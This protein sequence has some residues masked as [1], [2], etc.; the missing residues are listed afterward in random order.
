[1]SPTVYSIPP[2]LPFVDE[3]ARGVME[4]AGHDPLALASHLILLPTR[5][6]CRS[7]R[8]AFLRLSKGKPLLLP[9][10]L[11]LGEVEEE[12]LAISLAS[13]EV[14]PAIPGLKRQLLL[15][16]L[17]MAMGQGRGGKPPGPE[18]AAR[19]AGELAKLLDQVQTE[20]LSFDLLE[21]LVPE[22]L[23]EHWQVTLKFL[24]ILTQN[25]PVLLEAHGAADPSTRRSLLLHAQAERW[26]KEPPHHPVIAAGSTGS[27]PAAAALLAVIANLPQ[28][29]VVLPGLDQHMDRTSWQALDE[30]H[31][32]HGMKQLL[33]KLE[34]TPDRV[35]P[36]SRTPN[37]RTARAWLIAEAMRPA[38]TTDLWRSL[39]AQAD[40]AAIEGVTRL[41]CPG[42]R[43]EAG[44]IAMLLR[45]ALETE[46][47]TAALITPDR[48]LARRVAAELERWD[49]EVDDSAGRPL[50]LTPPGVFL[51]LAAEMVA[52]NFSPHATLACLKHPLAAAGLRPDQCRAL[53]RRLEVV[54]LRGARPAPGIEG[55][56][57]ALGEKET[58]LKEWL[59]ILDQAARPFAA[60]MDKDIVPLADLVR[61]HMEFAEALATDDT[62]P[63][64]TRLWRGEAGEVA[65]NFAADLGEAAEAMGEVWP[66]AYPG[67]LACL[68]EGVVVRP[69]WGRHPRL[70]IWGLLEARL[71][72]AD[73]IILGG[74]NEGSW[75]PEADSDPWMSR[76]M[77]RD[78]GLPSPERRVGL[79]AHDFVQAFC[80]PRVVMTR[81]MK[82]EGT[83]TVPSRWLLRLETVMRACGLE[84]AAKGTEWHAPHWLDWHTLLDAPA[85]H[86]PLPPPAPRPPVEARPR[87]L[88]VTQI[89]T[90]MR[91]PYA[92]YARH[93]LGLEALDPIDADPGAADYG[94]LVH[95]ALET[96]TRDYPGQ[97]PDDAEAKL[98]ETGRAVFA[99]ALTRP[100]VW[101][102][103]WPRF[104]RI[105]KWFIGHEYGRRHEIQSIIC[106][107][108][109]RLEIDADY[110]PFTLTAKADRIDRMKDG[111]LTIIDYKTGAVPSKK[112]VAAGY[113]PQLPLEAAIA[114]AGGFRDIPAAPV[115]QLLYW[116]LRGNEAGGEES[117][118]GDDCAKLVQ[119]ALDG[120]R[121]L[122]QVFDNPDTPY[123]A[124]PHPDRAPRYSDYG[125]LARVKEWASLGDDEGE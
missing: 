29:A 82:N 1:M 87:R 81:A 53:V 120:L 97:L 59:G 121:G 66:R 110:A 105:A 43:E 14:P 60:L 88:S 58:E 17:I 30:T 42:P 80:A 78:F 10:M 32:Q 86:T 96:F 68:M 108:G 13:L 31:P 19:L 74:L 54:V 36:W 94:N 61:A 15:A 34:I 98:I 23:A 27:N 119:E 11:P 8:E 48:N 18:Q 56:C 24:E 91:D 9:R 47:R 92:I 116:R 111:S 28:G 79:A 72:H 104:E 26:R 124:R 118:A 67:L 102:F 100:G 20:D 44:A 21:K 117:S 52:E 106:E 6:A 90:W 99:E 85:S 113:A 76:P 22:N 122:V 37:P 57:A 45:E 3:L 49:I 93:I 64:P 39:P 125:H 115:S 2:G 73:L 55:L 38:A 71:Q 33:E 109:G 114:Q 51:L 65:A 46:G 40:A 107:S 41:D 95:K 83:P 5:R 77:R 123:E 50:A 7:L 25:W 103:W 69:V 4:Q 70:H 12:E 84:E 89:E 63:G 112:E 35:R 62:L 16:R 101:A 75:P